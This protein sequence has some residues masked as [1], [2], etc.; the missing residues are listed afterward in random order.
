MWVGVLEGP[1]AIL[2][3]LEKKKVLFLA[4]AENWTTSPPNL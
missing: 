2:D 4:F 1:K 3:T